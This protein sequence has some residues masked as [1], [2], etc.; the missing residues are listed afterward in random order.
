[1]FKVERALSDLRHS[2]ALDTSNYYSLAKQLN[3][4]CGCSLGAFFLFAT[5]IGVSSYALLV[6]QSISLRMALISVLLVFVFGILGKMF[7]LTIAWVRLLLLYRTLTKLGKEVSH[8]NL[9][10]MGR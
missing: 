9:H 10:K 7:G 3:D 2:G 6:P 8:V 5:L 4:E 1:M